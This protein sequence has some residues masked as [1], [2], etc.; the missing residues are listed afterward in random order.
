MK[1]SFLTWILISSIL[2]SACNIPVENSDFSSLNSESWESSSFENSSLNDDSSTVNSESS[3][4]NEDNEMDDSKIVIYDGNPVTIT[5]S[6][7]LGQTF[8]NL[9]NVVIFEF[10]KIYPNITIEL[11]KEGINYKELKN[12]ITLSLLSG[13]A[14][15]IAYC[16]PED[17]LLYN[18]SNALLDLDDYVES[19]SLVKR[20]DDTSE[21]FGFTKA[22]IDDYYSNFYEEGKQFGDVD[23]DGNNDMMMLPLLRATE[24]LYYNKTFFEQNNLTVPTTW[25]EMWKTCQKIREIDDRSIPLTY[26]DEANYFMT[27]AEQL[28][29]PYLSTDPNE[30]FPFNNN[31]NR[32]FVSDFSEYY[33]NSYCIGSIYGYSYSDNL[34][35]ETD[36]NS[37]KS[38]MCIGSSADSAYH[39]P[40]KFDDGRYAFEVGC[41]MLPQIDKKNPKMISSSSQSL[42]LFKQENQ[43]KVA[44]AWLFAKY[45]STSV[46]YQARSAGI[47]GYTS[48]IKSVKENV[49]YKEF[50][51]NANETNY[52]SASVVNLTQSCCDYFFTPPFPQG[53]SAAKETFGNLMNDCVT[54]TPN[55][56]EEQIDMVERLFNDAYKYLTFKYGF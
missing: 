17:I 10:N 54:K 22:Q 25:E 48:V 6:H 40:P 38:Y 13:N 20:A 49:F 2:L 3:D 18:K 27:M 12:S 43:Q 34:F 33:K 5:I 19:A 4:N 46:E 31:V 23:G 7:V 41:A 21:A 14:P 26:Q 42:C 8:Q 39:I 37:I 51:S 9:L 32:Q 29:S 1:K 55:Y 35:M 44:A 24:V 56:G 52:L 47:L 15:S 11:K 45:L 16:Q 53:F 30:Y 28:N 50:L 36:P